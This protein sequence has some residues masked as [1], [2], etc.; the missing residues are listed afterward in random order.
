MNNEERGIIDMRQHKFAM[1]TKVVIDDKSVL[2][3]PVEKMVYVVLCSLADNITK[4]S[5]P[6]VKT[7]GEKACCSENTVRA[8]LKRLKEVGLIDV[9]ERYLP[10]KGRTS[11]R[12]ILLEPPGYYVDIVRG[13][14]N[15]N[16]TL[17]NE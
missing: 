2:R 17:Q 9:Q 14:E 16:R 8:A 10:V 11:N 1:V 15:D 7:I 6:T 4:D 13:S 5:W 3:K 12:Y